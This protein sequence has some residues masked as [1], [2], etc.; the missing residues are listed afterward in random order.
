MGAEKRM[1]SPTGSCA[2]TWEKLGLGWDCPATQA[3]A[4]RDK[5]ALSNR[6]V[7]GLAGL[8]QELKGGVGLIEK[9]KILT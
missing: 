6:L 8:P 4:G 1:T 9:N 3:E 2:G 5:L 7:R